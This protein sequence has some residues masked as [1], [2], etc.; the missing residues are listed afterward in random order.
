MA[1]IRKYFGLTVKSILVTLSTLDNNQ[2]ERASVFN[3]K[4]LE[5]EDIVNNM[6]KM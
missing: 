4:T 6:N 1:A 3:I 5:K 2:K